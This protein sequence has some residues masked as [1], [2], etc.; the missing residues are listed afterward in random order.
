MIEQARNSIRLYN[1][2]CEQSN[3]WFLR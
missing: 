3:R 2:W 1:D